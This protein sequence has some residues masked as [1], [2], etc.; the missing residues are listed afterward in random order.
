[1]ASIE[2]IGHLEDMSE[3]KGYNLSNEENGFEFYENQNYVRPGFTFKEFITETE[4]EE[5][6]LTQNAKDRLLMRV[7]IVPDESASE[8]EKYLTHVDPASLSSPSFTQFTKYCNSRRLESCSQFETTTH[9]FTAKADLSKENYI[10]FSV[11][12]EKG[13]SAYVNGKETTIN[14]VD[15]GFMAI[16]APA[17][18]STIE[19][20][21]TPS[22]Y[23]EG[24]LFSLAGVIM[25]IALTIIN[26]ITKSSTRR[27]KVEE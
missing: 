5:T 22:L 20:K 24:R 14:K 21:Y 3:L 16:L 10:F 9:G 17:G 25:L 1:M 15:Y 12:Y 11:P 6:D 8:Y 7:L 18:E 4:Y 27:E 2:T 13:F 26:H 23:K 19:F